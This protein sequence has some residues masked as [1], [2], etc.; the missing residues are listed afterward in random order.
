MLAGGKVK[1]PKIPIGTPV[2]INWLDILTE[3]S[4]CSKEE[5]T[6]IEPIECILVGIW[7]KPGPSCIHIASNINESSCDGTTIPIGC[8][9]GIQVLK[10]RKN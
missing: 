6:A 2:Q 5:F 10:A 3:P 9:I 4:W 1:I 7:M 8:V